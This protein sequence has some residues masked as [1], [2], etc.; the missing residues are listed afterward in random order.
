VFPDI[1]LVRWGAFLKLILKGAEKLVLFFGGPTR[2]SSIQGRSHL[3][4]SYTKVLFQRLQLS[5]ISS[6]E[7]NQHA[8][9]NL[10]LFELNEGKYGLK[11]SEFR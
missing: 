10:Q 5:R 6:N 3:S 1:F 4:K 2:A 9:T 7:D 11:V 8:V